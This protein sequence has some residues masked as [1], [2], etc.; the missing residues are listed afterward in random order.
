MEEQPKE[1]QQIR[2]EE[3]IRDEED[4]FNNPQKELKGLP[5]VY[6]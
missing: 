1:E 2:E 6:A 5:P 4:K 3:I